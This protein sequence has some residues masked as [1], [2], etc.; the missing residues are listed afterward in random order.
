MIARWLKR[1][2]C[3]HTFEHSGWSEKPLWGSGNVYTPG[4]CRR[5]YRCSQ[6]RKI[7]QGK[8]WY[9]SCCETGSCLDA[10]MGARRKVIG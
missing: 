8:E 10:L 7:E 5:V 6:C 3:S 9:F 2:F 1:L 4:F